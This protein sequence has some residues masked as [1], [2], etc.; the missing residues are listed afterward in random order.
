M[1]RYY[2]DS[3]YTCKPCDPNCLDCKKD[4]GKECTS[5]N[6]LS[7]YRFLDGTTCK[8]ACPFGTYGDTDEAKCLPCKA[9]CQSCTNGPDDC[10]T[11]DIKSEK[12][13]Y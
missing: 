13:Y 5:C 7:K 12:R 1:G 11:C 3:A 9:P 6:R 8:A 10:N 2:D 4:N